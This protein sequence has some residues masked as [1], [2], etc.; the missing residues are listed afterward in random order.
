M[1]RAGGNDAGMDVCRD[2]GVAER[3][4]VPGVR[5]ALR[6]VRALAALRSARGRGAGGDTP[7]PDDTA[8]PAGR[9]LN[10]IRSKETRATVEVLIGAILAF[11]MSASFAA[12][13]S[14]IWAVMRAIAGRTP[15]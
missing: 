12:L 9:G 11:A 15:I 1:K 5:G 8:S 14:V 2:A 7:L 4:R 3:V 6:G 13:M 10:Q